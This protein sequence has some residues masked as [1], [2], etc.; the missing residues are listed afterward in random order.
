MS[1]NSSM[2]VVAM[3]TVQKA[4]EVSVLANSTR[5]NTTKT[6]SGDLHRDS[7]Y[8]SITRSTKPH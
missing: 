1:I 6:T 4:S 7:I 3:E 2:R 8:T 5:L